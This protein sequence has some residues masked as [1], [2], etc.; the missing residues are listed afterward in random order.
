MFRS[1]ALVA[2]NASSATEIDSLIP[3]SFDAAARKAVATAYQ[4]TIHE[5]GLTGR[6]DPITEIV[7]RKIINIVQAGERD[8]A[9][10]QT[11]VVSGLAFSG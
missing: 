1:N 4:N 6:I 3:G 9:R 7:A 5:L 11:A 2:Q 10:I 8:P